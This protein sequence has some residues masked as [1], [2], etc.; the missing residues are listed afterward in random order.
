MMDKYGT[1]KEYN[2]LIINAFKYSEMPEIIVVVDKLIT[3]FDAPRN[4]VLYLTR[5]LKDHTLLQAIARVNRLYE[6]KEFGYII[7]Y[8]GVLENLDQALDLYGQM[9]EFDKDDLLNTVED[10]SVQIQTLPQKHSVLWDVFREVKNKRDEEA[11]ERLLSD[12]ALR[13]EFYERFSKYARTLA[14]ALSSLKFIEETP[15]KKIDEYRMDLK[16]FKE[17]RKSVQRRFA[18]V[19]D[20]SEYEP[21]IQKLIDTHIGTGEVEQVTGLVNIFDKDSFVKEVRALYGDAAKAD[22]IAHRTKKTIEERMQ[23]DPTFYK[24][25]SEL[26]KDVIRAFHEERI[27]DAEYLRRV[28]EIMKAVVKRTGDDIPE[29]LKNNDIAKAYYGYIREVFESHKDDGVETVNAAIEAS[30]AI[31]DIIMNMRIVNWTTN[32][33]R[34]NQMR[35]KIEDRIFELQDKYNFEFA[36]DEIDSIMDQCIDI[37]KVRVP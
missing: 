22:T 34:Q 30:L 27:K 8:R 25:F 15:G 28:E 17:L 10:V 3:G 33:D 29:S 26:L 37:A 19:I 14:I 4:T 16:F 23:E 12:D 7:D 11:F 24:K 13:N 5:K 32:S 18:E 31:D 9:S 1:E 21:K 36:F 2:R 6:G 35:N 20:F